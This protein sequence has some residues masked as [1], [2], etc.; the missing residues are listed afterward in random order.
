MLQMG[1]SVKDFLQLVLG[2]LLDLFPIVVHKNLGVCQ[3]LAKECFELVPRDR[4]RAVYILSLLILLPPEANLIPDER[5]GKKNLVSPRSSNNRTIVVTLLTEV[6]TIYIRLS[7]VH[8][9]GTGLQ[10]LFPGLLRD[11]KS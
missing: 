5:H 9:Q 2:F 4:D 11:G 7:A 6:V 8:V 10:R 1:Y 3:I